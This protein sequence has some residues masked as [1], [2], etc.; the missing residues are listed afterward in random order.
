MMDVTNRNEILGSERSALVPAG[1]GCGSPPG[2]KPPRPT[3]PAARAAAAATAYRADA[4]K[5]LLP[6][7][8][9]II[10]CS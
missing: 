7:I 4:M 3:A 1:I 8:L 5:I 9:K 2:P 6:S 10:R